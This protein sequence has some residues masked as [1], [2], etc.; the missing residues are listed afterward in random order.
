MG[1]VALWCVGPSQ[2]RSQTRVPSIGR[3][4]LNLWA[5]REALL[6]LLTPPLARP[7][8]W[9]SGVNAGILRLD[10]GDTRVK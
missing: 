6:C 1:L 5:S 8:R 7:R 10:A 3:Q 4:I 9:V 2:T